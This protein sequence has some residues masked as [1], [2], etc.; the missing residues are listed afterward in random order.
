MQGEAAELSSQRGLK[1]LAIKSFRG[2]ISITQDTGSG[3][4]LRPCTGYMC[5][6]PQWMAPCELTE[7]D[8]PVNPLES[9][10]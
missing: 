5:V 9:I 8:P 7:R 1:E 10:P 6:R 4:N 3:V 2:W